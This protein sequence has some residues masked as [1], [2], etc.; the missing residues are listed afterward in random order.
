[1]DLGSDSRSEE[2]TGT[3]HK[4]ALSNPS[5]ACFVFFLFLFFFNICNGTDFACFKVALIFCSNC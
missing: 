3:D 5:L 1:M 2:C 4:M